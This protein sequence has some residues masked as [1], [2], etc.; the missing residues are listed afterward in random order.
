MG[1]DMRGDPAAALLEVLDPEQNNTFQDHYIDMPFDLSQVMFLA[2]ANNPDTHPARRSGT[3]WRSSRCRATRAHEKRNIAK[4]FLVPKQLSAARPHRRAARVH[5]GGHRD[6]HRPLHARGRRARA[7]ARDRLG[8]PRDRDAPRRGRGRARDGHARARREGPRPAALHAPRSPS[9][10]MTPGVATGLAVDARA[11]ATSSS[12]RPTSMPGKGNIIVTGNLK[13]RDAGVGHDRASRS[14]AARPSACTSTPSASRA[15]TSTS[16]SPR[17]ARPRTAR[18]P[19]SRCSPRSR[20]LLL[21][22][23]AQRDV[24]MTGEITLR[25]ACLPVGGIKEKLLAAHRAGI[26][27]I[28]IP[29]R[30]RPTST[31]CPRTSARQL[32]DPPRQ[33]R[34]RG[35]AARARP[36]RDA[37][38]CRRPRAAADPETRSPRR[39]GVTP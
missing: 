4:E 30:T 32:R 9:A 10:T 15:S 29:A 5:A 12:S 37:R 11:A 35:P 13:Q 18:A 38:R 20:S 23:P 24:A 21:E 27:I 1:V 6:D 36:R 25:G 14:C 3:A 16:T 31:R 34:R 19:A 22:L 26:K 2:T 7:R 17:A 28:V 8:V 39:P 33:T